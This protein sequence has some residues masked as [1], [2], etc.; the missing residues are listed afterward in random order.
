MGNKNK[1]SNII[2]LAL[3]C[4]FPRQNEIDLNLWECQSPTLASFPL[5][6]NPRLALFPHTQGCHSHLPGMSQSVPGPCAQCPQ[7]QSQSVLD[8]G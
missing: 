7:T 2:S 4:V 8:Q 3:V 6:N 5:P 1:F